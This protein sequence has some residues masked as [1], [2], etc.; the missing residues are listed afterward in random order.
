MC[1]TYSEIPINFNDFKRLLLE[2]KD[3]IVE[4]FL[5]ATHIVFY[6]TCSFRKHSN[7][8]ISSSIFIIDYF[9]RHN[10]IV[11][12]TRAILMELAST[13]GEINDIYITYL[14]QLVS[15]GIKVILFDEECVYDV[16]SECFSSNSSIN[17]FLVWA[18][19]NGKLPAGTTSKTLKNDS[20]LSEGVLQAKHHNKSDLYQRFFSKVRKN[21]ECGDNL[22][23]ELIGIC[24]SI[25]SHM[26]GI[27][28]GKLIVLT[29]DKG[30]AG[31]LDATYKKTNPNFRGARYELM[32]TPKMVQCI[33]NEDVGITQ[34]EMIDILAQGVE[35]N[36]V[37]MGTTACDLTVNPNISM[38][39]TDLVNKIMEPNGIS[40]VF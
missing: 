32:S 26:P 21:K 9:L 36:L 19:R 6:D 8:N 11:V 28:D 3:I 1:K 4:E 35:G 18:V 25:L 13:S 2:D 22:G 16:L 10:A 29:E 14:N 23:E 38:K 34:K 24:V 30:A 40:I 7:I 37:V 5:S 15:S 27:S 31:H 33:F 12:V 39:A 17:N 20:K